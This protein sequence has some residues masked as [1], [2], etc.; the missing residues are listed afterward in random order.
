VSVRET[1]EREGDPGEQARGRER[2]REERISVVC[3][4]AKLSRGDS[5]TEKEQDP[6][7]VEGCVPG[8]SSPDSPRS[9]SKPRVS[10]IFPADG[11]SVGARPQ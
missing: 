8:S 9:L 10:S 7:G 5:K 11:E 1:L 6:W 3:F 4:R 2:K